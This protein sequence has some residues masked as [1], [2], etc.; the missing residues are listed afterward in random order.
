MIWCGGEG[1]KTPKCVG[2]EDDCYGGSAGTDIIYLVSWS[3]VGLGHET[4]A[5]TSLA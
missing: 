4:A 2:A 1:L 3:S 5:F